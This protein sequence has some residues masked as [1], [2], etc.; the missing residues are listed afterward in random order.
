MTIPTRPAQTGVQDFWYHPE[1][2]SVGAIPT[3]TRAGQLLFLSAQTAVDLDTGEIT[4]DLVD[5]P[6]NVRDHLSGLAYHAS[7]AEAYFGPIMAQTWAIYQNL[8]KILALQG[9][10]LKDIVRQR[11]YLTDIRDVGW[12]EQVMLSFFPD[13]KPSTLIVGVSNRSVYEDVRMWVD[14]VVLVPESG[15]LKKETIYL[16]ELRKVN[17]PYPQGV[18]VGQFLF[19][20]GLRGVD[21][22]TGRPVTTL[23]EL[24]VEG[25][26][27]QRTEG[28]YGNSSS[29]AYCA[30]WWL[31]MNGHLR[32]LLESQ[33][34]TIN[35]IVQLNGYWR[36]GMRDSPEREYLRVRLWGEVA[37]TPS[38]PGFAY[39]NLSPVNEIQWLASGLA[40]LPGTYRR[41]PGGLAKENTDGMIATLQKAGPIFIC[42]PLTIL[43]GKHQHVV[44]FADF[45]DDGRL[46]AQSR[47]DAGQAAMA[48]AWHC[49][50]FWKQRAAEFGASHILHQ[51]VY[52]A[53]L[54]VWPAY[55]NVA[56]IVFN[57]RVPPTTLIP[58]DD[59]QYV[60]RYHART[61]ESIRGER[62]SPDLWENAERVEIQT[63]GLTL[64]GF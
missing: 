41:E 45:A 24:G 35:D 14:C 6:T 62:Q 58:V 61:P 16:P 28:L 18:K 13:E 4:R 8:S 53:D 11:I 49:Y 46:Q 60:W 12:M 2:E 42:T 25:A 48:R 38:Q 40:L 15:G 32:R 17:G 3:G 59:S 52:L 21:A 31:S 34:A 20:D 56:R 30:Q 43:R 10:S 51:T 33:G 27:L 57:G 1:A 64:E 26:S 19:F 23:D 50:T 22:R 9:A 44:S 54:S 63:W 36:N 5:L 37:N 47:I 55:E 7:I 29:E 39:H